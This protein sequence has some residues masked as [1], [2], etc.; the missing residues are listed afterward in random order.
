[1]TTASTARPWQREDMYRWNK[2]GV[3]YAAMATSDWDQQTSQWAGNSY[4]SKVI[5]I[6]HIKSGPSIESCSLNSYGLLQDMKPNFLSFFIQKV[7]TMTIAYNLGW[8]F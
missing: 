4:Q 6:L 8:L 3:T 2:E 7:Q 1:M 5:R